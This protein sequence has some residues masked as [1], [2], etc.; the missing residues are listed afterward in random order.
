MLSPQPHA[1]D[2]Q[3]LTIRRAQ[4]FGL[5]LPMKKPVLMAGVRLEHSENFLIRLEEIGRAHV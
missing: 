5:R 1:L 2:L 4:A 3:P